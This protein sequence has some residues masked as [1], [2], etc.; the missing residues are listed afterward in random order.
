MDR[1]ARVET[2]QQLAEQRISVDEAESRL[3]AMGN[4]VPAGIP[5]RPEKSSS[6]RGCLMAIL[7]FLALTGLGLLALFVV[8]FASF[9]RAGLEGDV[10][11]RSS[12]HAVTIP[13]T[14]ITYAVEHTEPPTPQ[15]QEEATP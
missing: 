4:P 15:T 9:Q 6:G 7:V 5:T 2:L 3:T 1:E 13:D 10:I 14:S 11:Y 12:V 8:Y